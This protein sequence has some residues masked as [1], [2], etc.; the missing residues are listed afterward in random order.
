VREMRKRIGAESGFSY[1]DV[2]IAVTILLVGVLT[3]GAALTGAVVSTGESEERL[4]A[5]QYA[6]SVLESVLAAP[7]MKIAGSSYDFDSFDYQASSVKGKFLTGRQDLHESPGSDGLFLTGDT[8]ELASPLIPGFKA[9]VVFTSDG[10]T[11][12]T[13]KRIDVTVYYYVRGAE[14]SERLSSGA[15]R[16]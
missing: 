4:R 3:F 12:P 15:T 13:E 8:A 9:E 16:Y 14:R 5:K 11:P 1:I 6:T 10:N 7:T 2:M